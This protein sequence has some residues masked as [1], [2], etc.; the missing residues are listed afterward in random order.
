MRAERGKE[1]LP[2]ST[3]LSTPEMEKRCIKEG[4]MVRSNKPIHPPLPST[5]HLLCHQL[6]T[7]SPPTTKNT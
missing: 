1:N 4:T 5:E 7:S 2:T 3:S 6:S